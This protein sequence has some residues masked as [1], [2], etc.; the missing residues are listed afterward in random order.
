VGDLVLQTRVS[1]TKRNLLR[2]V[3]LS[4]M[5]KRHDK[6]V[7]EFL[8]LPGEFDAH[9]ESLWQKA[10]ALQGQVGVRR[11]EHDTGDDDDNVDEDEGEGEEADDSS[12]AYDAVV[13][14]LAD[15]RRMKDDLV[16]ITRAARKFQA[17]V[18]QL[19]QERKDVNDFLIGSA[20]EL[21]DK[22]TVD[23][24]LGKRDRVEALF[25]EYVELLR[26]IAL[27]H[28]GFGDEDSQLR[29]LFTI[30]D[31]MPS[32]WSVR[33]WSWQ[34]VSVPS[35]TECKEPTEASVLRIGFPEWTVWALPF[36]Q[37]AFAHVFIKKETLATGGGSDEVITLADALA[38]TATGPAYAC[39]ALLLRLDP[40]AVNS[41]LDEAALRSAS[42]MVA[43][44][45]GAADVAESPVVLLVDRLRAEWQ[46]AVASAGG[47]VDAF[48]A[49]CDSSSI[50]ERV[51]LAREKFLEFRDGGAVPAPWA[52]RWATVADWAA[53]LRARQ[54]ADIDLADVGSVPTDKPVTLVLLLNAA[55]L[56]RVGVRPEEDA[57]GDQLDAIAGDAVARMLVSLRPR[58]SS[59]KVTNR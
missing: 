32:I 19:S 47:D 38:T 30:A 35:L 7:G 3:Q 44:E 8:E 6:V 25:S 46:A 16:P 31:R 9:L 11:V 20:K 28:A 24:Y 57:G 51:D 54:A 59:K 33:G 18:R 58:P 4:E 49:A 17:E 34:S 27:R 22:L 36:V 42:I 29:D 39:A 10:Y 53:K 52:A 14:L 37:N 2:I 23:T 21:A 45:R 55:W 1:V 41:P 48:R 43:L 13:D 50:Q 56:A 12:T 5:I 26:G 40:A 15:I